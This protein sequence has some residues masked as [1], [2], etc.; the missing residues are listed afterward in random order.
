MKYLVQFKDLVSGSIKIYEQVSPTFEYPDFSL[1][2][3]RIREYRVYSPIYKA[4]LQM[5]H[6]DSEHSL[7]VLVAYYRQKSD[8]VG[9]NY[10][11]LRDT[12]A[13]ENH[14]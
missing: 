10:T 11:R 4:F 5:V 8:I 1:T 7:R 2:A 13:V 12:N 14:L 9:Y 6:G 3:G